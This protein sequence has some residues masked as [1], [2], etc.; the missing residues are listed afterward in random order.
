[1]QIDRKAYTPVLR[2]GFQVYLRR[3]LSE[4]FLA[5]KPNLLLICV[6]LAF[7]SNYGGF[8]DGPTFVLTLLGLIPL[9]ERIS[10]VT[11]DLAKMTNDTLG[12]LM[13]ATMGNITEMIVSIFALKHNLLR[14]VQVSLIGSVLSNMLLVLGTAFLVG[15][16]KHHSQKYEQST[17]V[18]NIGLLLLAVLGLMFPA[19]MA[20]TDSDSGAVSRVL[21]LSRVTGLVMIL[22]YFSL[23]FYQLKTHQHLFEGQEDGD[24]E[25]PIL[26]FWGCMFWMSILTIFIAFLSEFMV[27]AIEGAADSLGI[28]VLF[29]GTILLPI[30]G[31]AAEHASAIIFAYRDRMN[32]CLGIAVGS[33][34]QISLFVIPF[35]VL[36]AWMMDRELSMNFHVFETAVLFMTVIIVA[37]AIQTGSSDWLKG[38]LLVTAYFLV[39]ASFWVHRDPV[40]DPIND[41]G[42]GGSSTGGGF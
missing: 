21:A 37:F 20:E 12:G 3:S 26:G 29:I 25:A 2:D 19:V 28:P 7:A 31:N 1:V 4:L 13:N 41:S 17:A 32:I 8:G 11:E 18:T 35:I 38:V 6:P 27:S 33:A 24:E 23:I 40:L 9:A 36:V 14:V 22:V 15:G 16:F 34:T 39:S 10:F 5:S 30:V 42:S